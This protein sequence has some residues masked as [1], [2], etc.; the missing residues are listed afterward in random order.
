MEEQDVRDIP[1]KLNCW[2]SSFRSVKSSWPNLWLVA[3][4]TVNQA[5]VN[6]GK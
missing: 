4:N 6:S 5:D 2:G 3:K 1:L